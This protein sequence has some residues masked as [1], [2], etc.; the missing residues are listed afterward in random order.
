MSPEAASVNWPITLGPYAW[1]QSS[2]V[3]RELILGV[4][5]PSHQFIPQDYPRRCRLG[6]K[7]VTE[8]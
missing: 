2:P 6:Y 3:S 5:L 4:P 1:L 8:R 7:D